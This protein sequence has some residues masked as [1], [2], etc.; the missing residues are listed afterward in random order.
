MIP[1]DHLD[2][3]IV[4]GKWR[5]SYRIEPWDCCNHLTTGR[6]WTGNGLQKI[7]KFHSP[8]DSQCA[9]CWA[10]R[11]RK[12]THTDHQHE[13]AGIILKQAK[14]I[15]E[16]QQPL[17]Q[18]PFH[19]LHFVLRELLYYFIIVLLSSRH[20]IQYCQFFLL[21]ETTVWFWFSL[22]RQT[23]HSV[24]ARAQTEMCGISVKIVRWLAAHSWIGNGLDV[25]YISTHPTT[26]IINCLFLFSSSSLRTR[27]L[28]GSC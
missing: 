4:Q 14:M 11:D 16:D 2:G 21:F 7:N 20:V 1:Y 24:S 3:S 10:M 18:S 25:G 5:W 27:S 19:L 12:D 17:D 22:R 13:I 8:V 9:E 28:S 15:C 26:V 23:N 6:R